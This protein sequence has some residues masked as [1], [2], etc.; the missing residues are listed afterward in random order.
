MLTV[1][2]GEWKCSKRN[3]LSSLLPVKNEVYVLASWLDVAIRG[4][5]V[6]VGTDLVCVARVMKMKAGS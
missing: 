2:G 3:L 1:A 6:M 5:G 4:G